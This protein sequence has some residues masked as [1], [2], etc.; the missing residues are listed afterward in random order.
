MKE[1]L[2]GLDKIS[3]KCVQS[4]KG[5]RALKSSKHIVICHRRL[6]IN[7]FARSF[8]IEL[9]T[10]S[11]CLPVKKKEPRVQ[12]LWPTKRAK[13]NCVRNDVSDKEGVGAGNYAQKE[14]CVSVEKW[15]TKTTGQMLLQSTDF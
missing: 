10:G 4:Q 5:A 2:G 12:N 7:T 14:Q 9:F 11:V 1:S 13:R 3:W 6:H 8:A 15:G